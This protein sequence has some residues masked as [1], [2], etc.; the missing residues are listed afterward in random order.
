MLLAFAI[1]AI[2]LL[3]PVNGPVI[4]GYSPTGQYSGHWGVDYA[5]APGEQLR[6]PAG[7]SVTFAGSV[8]G[9]NSVTIEPVSGFK[10]SV[11]YLSEVVVT[12]GAH[13]SQGQL[14]GLAGA[15]HG[16]AGV[17]MSTRID[18]AYVNPLGQLGCQ[19]TDISRALRLVTP[20]RPYPRARANRNP[21][22]DLRS[23]P[24]RTSARR[25]SGPASGWPRPRRV[26][27]RR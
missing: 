9:M 23:H 3:S 8:A 15:A 24:Y 16:V 25:G 20:P 14:I 26:H 10:V 18:G 19:V 4:A 22:R 27:S 17:H 13:V 5:V 2:C 12:R 6:A 11:S 21:R 1:G 7:G